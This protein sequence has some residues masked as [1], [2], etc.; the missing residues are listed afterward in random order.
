MTEQAE[1]IS[2]VVSAFNGKHWTTV[3][4]T[5]NREQADAML[6][7]LGGKGRLETFKSRPRKRG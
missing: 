7:G 5:T 6:K 2:Y 1:K 3:L 4:T